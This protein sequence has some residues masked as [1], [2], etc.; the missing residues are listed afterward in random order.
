[1]TKPLKSYPEKDRAQ[2]ARRRVKETG[3]GGIV[4]REFLGLS[5]LSLEEAKAN[6]QSETKKDEEVENV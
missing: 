4:A 5:T 6:I 2:I 1:M 3:I